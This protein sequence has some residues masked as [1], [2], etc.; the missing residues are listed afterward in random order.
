M[1]IEFTLTCLEKIKGTRSTPTASDLAVRKG[2]LL[3]LGSS[4]IE[5]SETVTPPEKIASLISPMVTL[6][7]SAAVSLVS[8][9][10]LNWLALMKSGR[11]R[12]RSSTTATMAPIIMRGFFVFIVRL[13]R[14]VPGKHPARIVGASY[15]RQH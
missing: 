12:T 2:D 5:I 11:H 14:G 9:V 15:A 6:R 10:G 3:K 4:A 8:S 7:P 1:A 13:R